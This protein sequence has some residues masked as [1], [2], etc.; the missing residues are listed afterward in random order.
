MKELLTIR[1]QDI[2]P[3]YIEQ[4]D[5]EYRNRFAARAV[6]KDDTE[7]IA[8]LFAGTRQ[9]YKLPG[10]GIEEGEDLSVALARELL[11]EVGVEAEVY[12]E[13][14]RVE[15]WRVSE[16]RALHQV[17]DSFLAQVTGEIG[18]PS[19]TEQELAEGFEVHWAKDVKEAIEKI[20][21]TLDHADPEVRFMSLRDSAILKA[22]G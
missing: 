2:D 12:G 19:F 14:G 11:E 18:I 17:S 7:R 3:S 5:V 15:E 9:Y 1:Q 13:I 10:G 22:V 16:D 6:L 21:Q 20:S 8:L 4:P